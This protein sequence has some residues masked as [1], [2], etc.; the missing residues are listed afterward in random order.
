MRKIL[1]SILEPLR[2]LIQ[3]LIRPDYIKYHHI[4]PPYK[5]NF[6]LM[7]E[8]RLMETS[9]EYALKNFRKCLY[10]QITPQLWNYAAGK[11]RE[12]EKWTSD[13]LFLEFGVWV[14]GSINHF[15]SI[16]PNRKFYGFDSFEGLK[17]DWTGFSLPRGHFSLG[18]NL[19]KVNSNV[20]LVK[21]WFDATL[22][23]FIKANPENIAFL[24]ID[25]DTYESTKFVLNTLKEKI[26][27]GTYV[28]FDEYI[29]YPNWEIGEYKAFQEFIG[30]TGFRYKYVGFSVKQV[31]LIIE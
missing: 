5:H 28:L 31:L 19:P 13:K 16:I 6:V 1:K 20:S 30:E 26:I 27:P 21:G 10:F 23:G 24:H 12:N 11:L 15:S 9:I 22:P 2:A 4:M 14:G 17:E 3:Y 7:Y 18:G 8:E 25:C 29:G